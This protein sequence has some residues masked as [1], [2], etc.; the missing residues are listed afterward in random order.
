[1]TDGRGTSAARSRPGVG[2]QLFTLRECPDDLL[3]SLG[4]RVRL[5]HLKDGPAR[6]RADVMVAL[7]TGALDLPSVVR[8][9]AAVEWHIVELDRC[10]TD[11][12]GVLDQSRRYLAGLGRIDGR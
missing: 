12:Y 5:L 4:G 7:G 8:A 11:V 9:N 6:G 2:V 3:D 1:M 10:A